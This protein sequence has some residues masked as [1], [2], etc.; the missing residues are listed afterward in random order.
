MIWG[1]PGIGKSDIV[2]KIARDAG[3]PLIDMRLLLLDP[4]DLK[5]IPHYDA[6]SGTM[7]WAAPSDLPKENHLDTAILFLDEI[8]AAPPSVQAAAY[9]LML[10]RQI[11]E[12]RLPAGVSIICAGNRDGDRAVT[13][14][15]PSPLANRL[16]H[17][18]L[19][20][21]FDDW[22]DWAVGAGLHADV[23]GFLTSHR[24]HLFN[25]DP[26]STDHAFATPRSWQFV[27]QLLSDEV[28][29][30]LTSALVAGCVGPGI[31]LE[32]TEHRRMKDQLPSV[33]SVLDGTAPS[34]KDPNLSAIYSLT[35]SLCSTLRDRWVSPAASAEKNTSWHRYANNFFEFMM[36]NF[37][38]ELTIY[39]SRLALVNYGLNIDSKKIDCYEKFSE[40]FA[41]YII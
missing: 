33:E 2:A 29:E 1:P 22:H 6:A 20:V 39:G 16:V 7:R 36:N 31:A 8:V 10:N 12:Y 27:A 35:N 15:M 28:S 32:F 14:K 17:F 38:A 34:V 30:Q 21:N 13:F 3:R 18:E 25:F 9:Q 11:G 19:G 26:K 37:P 24:Q 23:I 5:G 40:K 4:T 41:K